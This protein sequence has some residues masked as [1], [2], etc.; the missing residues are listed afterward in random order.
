[1]LLVITVFGITLSSCGNNKTSSTS[2]N[3]SSTSISTSTSIINPSSY[4][5]SSQEPSGDLTTVDGYRLV[6]R[7][8]ELDNANKVI[9]GAYDSNQLYGMTPNAKSEKLPG[10]ITGESLKEVNDHKDIKDIT[11]TAVW[12]LSK[13]CNSYK[14]SIGG[15]ET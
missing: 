2:T 4:S 15:K 10:Y 12:D 5:S 1:M 14:F 11:I 8:N 6:T 3:S 13:T 7:V 9:I